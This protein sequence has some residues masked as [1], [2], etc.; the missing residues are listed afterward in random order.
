M[1]FVYVLE[2]GKDKGFYTGFTAN[3]ERR[4]EEHNKGL[5]CSTKHRL[6]LK[7]VYYECSLDKIDV[8]N[9]EKYLKSGI[10]KRFIK[11]RLKNYLKNCK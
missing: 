8:L 11:T 4:I 7:L 1:Y 9:R 2:S 5:Q 10:G 6:P 3:L